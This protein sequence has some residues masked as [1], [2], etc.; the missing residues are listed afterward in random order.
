[1][2]QLVNLNADRVFK[3]KAFESW[4][5]FTQGMRN[6]ITFRGVTKLNSILAKLERNKV[7]KKFMMWKFLLKAK[8]VYS[9]QNEQMDCQMIHTMNLVAVQL[10]QDVKDKKV[11]YG[12]ET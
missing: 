12:R 11:K 10:E 9:F 7:I 5:T 4:R 6:K 1:M 2:R 3:A 8:D